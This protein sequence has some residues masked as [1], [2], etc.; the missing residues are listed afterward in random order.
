MFLMARTMS[1]VVLLSSPARKRCHAASCRCGLALALAQHWPRCD[2]LAVCMAEHAAPG[3]TCGDLVQHEDVAG[4]HALLP[5]R[6][7]LLLTPADTSDEVVADKGAL[8][9]L[10]PANVVSVQ[11]PQHQACT[12]A[13]LLQKQILLTLGSHTQ[14]TSKLGMR[15]HNWVKHC[16]ALTF[17]VQVLRRLSRGCT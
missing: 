6:D 17:M 10:Q 7:A 15:R 13:V 14:L 4:P 12:A 8:A 2:Q 3:R 16:L 11:S 9:L 1:M 5:Q